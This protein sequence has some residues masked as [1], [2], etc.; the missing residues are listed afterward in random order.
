M[1]QREE[2]FYSNQNYENTSNN[3]PYQEIPNNYSSIISDNER[4][5][6]QRGY[7][8]LPES[9]CD[10]N[11]SLQ[12]MEKSLEAQSQL[13]A[14]DNTRENQVYINPSLNR[15]LVDK[16][17]MYQGLHIAPAESVGNDFHNNSG[18]EYSSVYPGNGGNAI[19]HND[20]SSINTAPLQE[21]SQTNGFQIK[22]E[23][24]TIDSNN[25]LSLQQNRKRKS[26]SPIFQSDDVENI[27][28]NEIIEIADDPSVDIENI[29]YEYDMNTENILPN[30]YVFRSSE[31]QALGL[32]DITN[33]SKTFHHRFLLD[34]VGLFK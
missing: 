9:L 11:P 22:I 8:R 33:N 26:S 5:L 20:F 12:L 10:Q 21:F 30:L 13:S 27:V 4:M 2:I 34:K 28:K 14:I 6:F 18:N 16:E 17:L 31:K 29:S 1:W 25:E 15:N 23:A 3:C 32:L 24:D 7:L 19:S